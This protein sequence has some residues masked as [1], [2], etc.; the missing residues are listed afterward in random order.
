MSVLADCAQIEIASA[1]E[2]R[3]WLATHHRQTGSIWLVT[4]KKGKGP[5]VSYAEI[6]DQA[7]CYG[8]I[9][10]RPAKLDGSRSML[11]L[12]PRRPGS[13]WSAINRAKVE[14][15]AERGLL[16]PPG[17][18]VIARAKADG[19]WS[20]LA[21]VDA[22]VPPADLQA[23]LEACEGAGPMWDRMPPSSR[24]G[25][26]EWITS[27]KTGETR[28]RRVAETARLAALGLKANFPAGRNKIVMLAL[29]ALAL[30]V[31]L[32]GQK[33]A[34]QTVKPREALVVSHLI[35]SDR[36]VITAQ[37]HFA[38]AISSLTFRG[39]N[40]VNAADHGRLMQ[41]AIAF[42]GRFECLN[43]TQAG[44][45]RD[46]LNIARR[47]S[48]RRLLAR[49]SMDGFEVKTRMAW[50]MRPGMSCVIPGVGRAPVENKGRLSDVTYA[51]RHRFTAR[52]LANA[53][54]VSI[55]YMS[56]KLWNS[57]VVEAL[58]IYT[59]PEFDTFHDFDPATGAI[60]PHPVP[61]HDERAPP[62]ILST[63]DGAHAVAFV[64]LSPGATYFRGRFEDT[65][66]ISLVYRP[67]GP[68]G[69]TFTADAVWIVGTRNEVAD[70]MQA[71]AR[72]GE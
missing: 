70:T 47:S 23:A 45:S 35:G 20:A 42:N 39:Q 58:T 38:G 72:A 33:V 24:R 57:A 6:V 55:T 71:L 60:T 68:F 30:A 41:G 10:S 22:N 25:I 13:N 31:T 18:A 43:P 59:P 67:P 15:L 40:Y 11:L 9:D 29:A 66:K 12:S 49:T 32:A 4:W 17:I 21:E 64:S 53:T 63:A 44:G 27:A 2:L 48:S 51:Q 37:P 1:G 5:H 62:P 50:W 19:S 34:A 8:W 54:A 14:A 56:P 7:L 3:A 46:R 16:A 65:T 28:A 69:G 36:M 26:L 61:V 52:G